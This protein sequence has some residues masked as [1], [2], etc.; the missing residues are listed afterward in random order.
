M[1]FVDFWTNIEKDKKKGLGV[2]V[3]I[4]R[5]WAAHITKVQKRNPYSLE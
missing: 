4:D 5:K 3:L 2:G 1:Y